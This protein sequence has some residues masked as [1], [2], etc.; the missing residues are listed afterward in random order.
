[1]RLERKSST[2]LNFPSETLAQFEFF[3]IGRI[4][5]VDGNWF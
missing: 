3:I 2:S 4:P 5:V 1:M